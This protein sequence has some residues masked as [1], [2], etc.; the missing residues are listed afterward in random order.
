MGKRARNIYFSS[1]WHIGHA[2]VI[3]FSNRPFNDVHHMSESLVKRYNATVQETDVCYFLGD[4]GYNSDHLR[5]V[6]VRLN[7]TKIL[8]LGNHD[9]KRQAM[10]N[11]GFDAVLNSGSMYIQGELVTMSHCPLRGVY[12]E[13]TEGMRGCDG[14]ENWHREKDHDQFSLENKGQ[15]HLHGH[16]HAPNSGKSEVQLDRQWDV[17]VD[18][19]GY[20]PVSISEVE[21]WIVKT[22]RKEKN[23]DRSAGSE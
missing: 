19:N 17:G 15:F 4:M 7:G 2:N 12:R 13:N 6:M 5:K 16:C 20:R 11:S 21:S 18:G 10:M 14:T 3:N 1:D 22:L 23:E 8:I 9:K